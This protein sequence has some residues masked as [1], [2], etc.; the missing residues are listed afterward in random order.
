MPFSLHASGTSDFRRSRRSISESD[1]FEDE[2]RMRSL[3]RRVVG[4]DVRGSMTGS[5]VRQTMNEYG[6]IQSMSLL[7]D[8]VTLLMAEAGSGS[9]ISLSAS[10]AGY[11]TTSTAFR[12]IAIDGGEADAVIMD[13]ITTLIGGEMNYWGVLLEIAQTISEFSSHAGSGSGTAG[14][15]MLLIQVHR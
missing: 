4:T 14:R 7:R 5:A 9:W 1:I 13:I 2:S 15:L 3:V 11:I 10:T 8:S 6:R 12:Q